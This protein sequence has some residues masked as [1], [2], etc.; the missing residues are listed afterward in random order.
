MLSYKIRT[1]EPRPSWQAVFIT[2]WTGMRGV[3]SLAAALALPTMMDNGLP[4][5]QRDLILF[6][7]FV[8]IM[9]TLVF[10]GLTLPYVVKKLNLPPSNEEEVEEQKARVELA[11]SA[12]LHIEE[13]YGMGIVHDDVLNQVKNKYEL[14]INHLNR[15]VRT[16]DSMKNSTVLF[17]QLN[18]MQ[19]DLLNVERDI[20]LKMH[21]KGTVGEEVLRRLEYELDLE[22]SRLELDEKMVATHV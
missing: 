16:E 4:F 5:P 18:R 6:V 22:E 20:I 19:K 10:Q 13:N 1:T 15:Q 14:K 3:V 12:I 8:I 21:K 2:G 7:T 17:N 11:S 9:F